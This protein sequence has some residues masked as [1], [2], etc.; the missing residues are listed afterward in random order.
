MTLYIIYFTGIAEPLLRLLGQ[1]QSHLRVSL[2]MQVEICWL[3]AF[4]TAKDD[5]TVE[6]LMGYGLVQVNTI[7]S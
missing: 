3:F 2:A 4:L 6:T 1:Q 5:F 7:L